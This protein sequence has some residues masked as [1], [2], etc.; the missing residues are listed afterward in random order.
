ML[1]K[2]ACFRTNW[3]YN[4]LNVC[5]WWCKQR[6]SLS[7]IVWLH[8][9]TKSDK[10]TSVWVTEAQVMHR[11]IRNKLK[12][13]DFSCCLWY[14]TFQ[15]EFN[16][17]F[18][19][20]IKKNNNVLLQKRFMCCCEKKQIGLSGCFRTKCLKILWGSLNLSN[21]FQLSNHFK[22]STIHDK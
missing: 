16:E 18:A 15:K 2:E 11:R 6:A 1:V 10:L 14:N 21:A 3:K 9:W 5:S 19:F 8:I 17:N 4:K 13:I 22:I 20:M 7:A 12:R